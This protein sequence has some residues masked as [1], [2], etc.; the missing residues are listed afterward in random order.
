MTEQPP[1]SLDPV[2][3]PRSVAVVGASR[4]ND[5]IG[6]ALVHNLIQNEFAGAVYPVNPN[7]EVVHS[8]RC[9][10]SVS[11]LPDPVDLA[12]IVL[13]RHLVID[14]VDECLAKGIRGLVVITAGFGEVG[15]EGKALEDDLLGRVR[16]AG[17]RM[18]GPNCMGVINANPDVRLNATFAP[19]PAEPG[20]VG[21]VTQ[22]GALG[23]A[24]LN[25]AAG[26]GIGFTQFVS[27]GNKADVS[28]NDLLEYWESDAATKVIAM[29][30][31]SFGNP[32]RF[33]QIAKRVSLKKPILIVKS[34]RTEAGA[35]AASSHTGAIAATDVTVSAFLDQCGV[36]RARTIEEM[37]D[38]A[39]ALDRCPWPRGKR[40]AIVTNAGGP[41]IMAT[42]SVIGL[43]LDL[44]EIGEE[45]TAALRSF[46]PEAASVVNP[47]DMI[48]AAGAPEYDAAMKCLLADPGI[49]MVLAIH[50]AP[51][52]STPQEILRA[53]DD[54][55]SEVPDK[56]V[57]VVMMSTE[58]AYAGIRANARSIAVYRFPESAAVALS[59]LQQYAQWR[60][61]P[62]TPAPE[63]EVDDERVAQMV[64]TTG[65]GFMDFENAF[66]V[67]EAYGIPVA[68]RQIVGAES[69]ALRAAEEIGYPIVLKAFGSA[70]IHK[71]DVGAV[72]VDL[73]SME[74]F[75]RA[76]REMEQR[77][78]SAGV[79]AEGF[80]VQEMIRGGHEVI[81]GLSSDKKLGSTVMFGLGGKYVEVF[82]D[83]RFGVPPLTR[84][85]A[86]EVID[87]LRGSQLLE[88]V[89][90]EDPIDKDFLVEILLRLVQLT[91]RHPDI[92]ELDINPFIA[93][94]DRAE[95]SAVD[96]RIRVSSDS[97]RE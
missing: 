24:I 22:S 48:A 51:L 57:A 61:R 25:V 49:D 65:A 23:V 8:L 18:V 16:A 52:T 12:L 87:G 47:I 64:K 72:A 7:T 53:I 37:F 97:S 50:V 55:A 90:G 58:D 73:R 14:V 6:Y 19:T 44:V 26:L 74:E 76:F 68:Q 92:A 21:F 93:T 83:V 78:Q 84:E 35:R 10:P 77:I 62:S 67:L 71:S 88:G 85:D 66:G 54:R 41:G 32:H 3:S 94:P 13:P 30:L 60:D 4:R 95:A 46:L 70:L 38:I 20:S 5:T 1:N 39:Q 86:R 79:R 45:T 42:D 40:V 81:Y 33:A 2:F 96:V 36:I 34:G 89:R 91:E 31:E 15:A 11:A 27:M 17:A 82:R 29:Y 43:G 56:P 75:Y 9:A 80:L 59:R 69:E 63:F 28:A